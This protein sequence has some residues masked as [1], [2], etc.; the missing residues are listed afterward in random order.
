[1]MPTRLSVLLLAVVALAALPGCGGDTYVAP[2]PVPPTPALGAVY[3]DNLTDQ[4]VPEFALGFFLARVDGP[5]TE[6]LLPGDLA[7]AATQY[8]GDFIEYSYDAEADM[9]LGDLVTWFDI[10]VPAFDDTFFEIY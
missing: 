9:E 4:G 6:N 3:V 7:P 1:M 5:F 10:W 8:V 2:P